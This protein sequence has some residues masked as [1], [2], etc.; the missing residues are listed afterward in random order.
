MLTHAN[1]LSSELFPKNVM[2]DLKDTSMTMACTSL[3]M[4][5]SFHWLLDI[6]LNS[7]SLIFP[8]DL[9]NLLIIYFQLSWGSDRYAARAEPEGVARLAPS[10]P[11]EK[12]LHVELELELISVNVWFV[13]FSL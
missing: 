8:P 6:C 9:F 5:S 10:H 4:L 3:P 1:D 2:Y 7:Y 12:S 11:F 13:Y